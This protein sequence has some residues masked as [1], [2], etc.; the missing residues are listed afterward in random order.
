MKIL[1]LSI[2]STDL[3]AV[4]S[5]DIAFLHLDHQLSSFP[6][7]IA[8]HPSSAL[9]F[10]LSHHVVHWVKDLGYWTYPASP[11]LL[12]SFVI[13]QSPYSPSNHSCPTPLPNHLSFC[14]PPDLQ[15]LSDIVHWLKSVA[16]ELY[17]LAFPDPLLLL[18]RS[19]HQ[20]LLE[21][22]L[23]FL[24]HSPSFSTSS[25]LPS[26]YIFSDSFQILLQDSSPL[27]KPFSI[28]VTYIGHSHLFAASLKWDASILL[29]EAYGIL[30]LTLL[31]RSSALSFDLPPNIFS[32]HLNSLQVLTTQNHPSF[33]ITSAYPAYY[34]YHWTLDIINS[35]VTTLLLISHSSTSLPSISTLSS[36]SSAHSTSL[37]PPSVSTSNLTSSSSQHFPSTLNPVPLFPLFFHIHAHTSSTSLPSSLNNL[38]DSVAWQS[39]QPLSILSSLSIPTFAI[40]DYAPWCSTHGFL[41]MPILSFTKSTWF[42]PTARH[43]GPVASHF[44]DPHSPPQY[45]YVQAQSGYATLI[46]LYMCS[47]QLDSALQLHTCPQQT[48]PWCRHGC[49]EL[50]T[51]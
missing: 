51:I 7:S 37:T 49:Y 44:Y 27:P 43:P 25:M 26:H 30:L 40:E 1:G 33:H 5:G 8:P 24:M 38:V 39:H 35:L 14:H 31:A 20:Q 2:Q 34:L 4:L 21:T 47:H 16:P 10:Y 11:I 6:G 18:P 13:H 50:E 9:L 3:S 29:A 12:P 15:S 22:Y 36:L 28:S 46:Q 48:Q 19:S 23:L 45:L 17:R 41:M 32:D 42:S